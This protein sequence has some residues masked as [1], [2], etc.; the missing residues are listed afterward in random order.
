MLFGLWH[1]SPTL[2]TLTENEQLDDATES[3][4]GA[5]L[6][7]AGTVLATFVAGVLFSW[8]RMRS[9][10]LLAPVIAHLATNGVALVVAWFVVR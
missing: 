6:L 10:S 1:I 3:T 8:L 9:R 4:G 5:I 2:G 7:V